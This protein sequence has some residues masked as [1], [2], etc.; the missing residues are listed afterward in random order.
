[1]NKQLA[2]SVVDLYERVQKPVYAQWEIGEEIGARIPA[3]HLTV[4]YPE[5]GKYL[6]TSGVVEAAKKFAGGADILGNVAVVAFYEHSSRAV[7]YAQAGGIDAYIP[8]AISLPSDYDEE[9]G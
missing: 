9:S 5:E 1:M 2:E 3:D 6:S 4:I 8:Q 7:K